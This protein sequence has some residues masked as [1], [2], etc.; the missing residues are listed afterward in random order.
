MSV[1]V[2]ITGVNGVQQKIRVFGRDAEKKVERGLKKAALF[3]QRESM[4]L[5]PVQF[6][7]LRSTAFTRAE[8]HGAKTRVIVGY[9]SQ[10]AVYV[11]ENLDATHGKAFNSKHADK[12]ASAHTSAQRRVWFRRGPNQVAKFLEIPARTKQADL[13]RII[14]GEARRK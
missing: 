4:K 2:T 9:T 6:G 3:L 5:V 1:T 10:Y 12:I 13:E 14:K 11:H 7:I 8:G